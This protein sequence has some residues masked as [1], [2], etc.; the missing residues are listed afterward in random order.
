M[1]GSGQDWDKDDCF[2]DERITYPC[3]PETIRP[4]SLTSLKD[5]IGVR[6]GSSDERKV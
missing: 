2:P 5:Q 6:V 4:G 3:T 1:A